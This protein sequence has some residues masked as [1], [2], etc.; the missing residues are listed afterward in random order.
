MNQRSHH[1]NTKYVWAFCNVSL[2]MALAMS[3]LPLMTLLLR[4][5]MGLESEHY[6]PINIAVLVASTVFAF[7]C[8]RQTY[9]FG[10]KWPLQMVKWIWPVSFFVLLVPSTVPRASFIVLGF[11]LVLWMVSITLIKSLLRNRGTTV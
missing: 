5:L 7:V 9:T 6:T 8:V 10:R 1:P 11:N 3:L 4:D 2:A